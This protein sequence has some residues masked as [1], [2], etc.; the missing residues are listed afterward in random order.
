MVTTNNTNIVVL[1][2][3]AILVLGVGY[4]YHRSQIDD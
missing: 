2:A 3:C 1:V 4:V